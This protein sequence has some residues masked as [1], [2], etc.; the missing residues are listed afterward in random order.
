MLSCDLSF[1][2]QVEKLT[3]EELEVAIQE[4]NKPL[5][6]DFYA[7]W[8]GPCLLLAKELEEVRYLP[9][10]FAT[11]ACADAQWLVEA[12]SRHACTHA[13]SSQFTSTA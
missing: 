7:T 11:W 8:C 2:A 9:A 12:T 3:A 1:A 4:R 10:S 5:I 13:G 6:I